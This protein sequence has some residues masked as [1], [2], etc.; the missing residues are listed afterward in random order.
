[1]NKY[2]IVKQET[3]N[4]FDKMKESKGMTHDGL[5][6]YLINEENKKSNK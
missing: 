1:M 3:K 5:L 2:I 4:Q 6:R